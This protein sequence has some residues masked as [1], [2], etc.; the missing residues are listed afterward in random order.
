MS[1]EQYLALK[2][3]KGM[4][5]KF[6]VNI[7]IGRAASVFK[8]IY[9]GDLYTI[10][11]ADEVRDFLDIWTNPADKPLV[12]E[13]IS[14]MQPQVQTF[15]LKF[16]EEAPMPLIILAS[17]DNVSPI[18]LSRCKNI[19]KL[20]NKCY[21]P[22]Q[23]LEQYTSIKQEYLDEQRQ[24]V[25]EHKQA[26]IIPFDDETESHKHC[27]EYFYQAAKIKQSIYNKDLWIGLLNYG[28][29]K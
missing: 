21:T 11:T 15:L 6:H 25:R 14:L 29:N 3:G 18:I 22:D 26:S 13:D 23:S 19:V 7:I 8:K 24:L 2:V 20:E 1:E 10:T 12:F 4:A 9:R 28:K 16:I 17:K 27:P 5:E